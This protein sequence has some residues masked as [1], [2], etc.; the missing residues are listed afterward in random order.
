MK[1]KLFLIVLMTFLLILPPS[2]FAETQTQSIKVFVDGEQLQ[3]S[4]QPFIEDG[5]TLVQFRPVFEKLGLKISWDESSRTITGTKSDLTIKLKIDSQSAVVNDEVRTLVLAPRI[6]NGSTMVPLRFISESSKKFVNWDSNTGIINISSTNNMTSSNESNQEHLT[7]NANF[8]NVK[9]GMSREEI[10]NLEK[11]KFLGEQDG[12]LYYS[13]EILGIKMAVYY[14]F[15]D[16]KLVRAILVHNDTHFNNKDYILDYNTMK[17]A[18]NNKYGNSTSD[19]LIWQDDIYKNSPDDYGLAVQA[20]HLEYLTKWDLK[21]TNITE[22]MYGKDFKFS[23][24]VEFKSK[25]YKDLL[26]KK[27]ENKAKENLKQF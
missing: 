6:V 9:W 18:L 17:K 14:E 20:G 5:V 23:F 24:T 16:N 8:R 4:E 3:F 11:V 21:E 12:N 15:I 19:Q 1:K 10:K 26:D 25:E 13:D 27:E 22:Y 7:P 2:A